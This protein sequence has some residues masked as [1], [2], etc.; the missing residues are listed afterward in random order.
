MVENNIGFQVDDLFPD[1]L[2]EQVG[3]GTGLIG[4]VE[5]GDLVVSRL[6]GKTRIS[7]RE[8]GSRGGNRFRG[9]TA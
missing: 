8:E 3:A 5:P 9:T 6:K 1:R 2:E 7:L 4:A